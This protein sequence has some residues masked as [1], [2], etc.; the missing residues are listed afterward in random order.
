MTRI[1]SGATKNKT[2][3]RDGTIKT[4]KDVDTMDHL[5]CLCEN[6]DKELIDEGYSMLMIAIKNG[7]IK[8]ARGL[9]TTQNL[10]VFSKDNKNA[11]SVACEFD[12]EDVAVHIYNTLGHRYLLLEKDTDN[13]DPMVFICKFKMKKMFAHVRTK[14]IRNIEI[15]IMEY[16]EP[17]KV[18]NNNETLFIMICKNQSSSFVLDLLKDDFDYNLEHQ[19]NDGNT[20]LM[21]A[22]E[23]HLSNQA[24]TKIIKK[25]KNVNQINKKKENAILLSCA[26]NLTKVSLELLKNKKIDLTKTDEYENVA[27]AYASM[28]DNL[29]VVE[30]MT[31]KECNISQV[32][33]QGED[34]LSSAVLNNREDIALVIA[35]KWNKDFNHKYTIGQTK[36]ADLPET[37]QYARKRDITILMRAL[38]FNMTK[39]CEFII[40]SGKY[41]LGQ[42]D[43]LNKTLLI[44]LIEKKYSH[45]AELV[46]KSDQEINCGHKDNSRTTALIYSGFQNLPVISSLLAKRPDCDPSCFNIDDLDI[47]GHLFVNKYEN[48]IIELLVRHKVL[49]ERFSDIHYVAKH[50]KMK[51]LVKYLKNK[52]IAEYI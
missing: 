34:A 12:R 22:I 11:L 51:K 14:K 18:N 39:L 24:I 16:A 26:K 38:I 40:L 36:S 47:M 23:N 50:A 1:M 13:N 49:K 32:D 6:D 20:A 44:N 43:Y 25:M 48:I 8:T 28:E 37:K 31:E 30:K 15:N 41:D 27:L 9:M 35:K 4:I 5:K 10:C 46:L 17:E 45:L 42:V 52:I 19:D 7:L 33:L 3:V 29:Q 2:M 21:C